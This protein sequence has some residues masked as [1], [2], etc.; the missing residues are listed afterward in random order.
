MLP[1]VQGLDEL[2]DFHPGLYV[3][4][5]LKMVNSSVG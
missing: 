1:G 4:G 3:D 5:G 2:L